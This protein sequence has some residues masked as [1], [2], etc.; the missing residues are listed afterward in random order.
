[1]KDFALLTFS[2]ESEDQRGIFGSRKWPINQFSSSLQM[3]FS[4]NQTVPQETQ[5]L[6][7]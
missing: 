1:M 6:A 5:G 7:I 4:T 2:F 3:K